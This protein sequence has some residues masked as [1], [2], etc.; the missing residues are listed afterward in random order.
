MRGPE[1][2]R[3]TEG[4]GDEAGRRPPAAETVAV[5]SARR[6]TPRLPRRTA[7]SPVTA[8]RVGE[9]VREPLLGA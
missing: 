5:R 3:R 4:A 7:W 1:G 6:R 9:F 8:D 2:R